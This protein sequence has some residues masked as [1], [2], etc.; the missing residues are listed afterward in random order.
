MSGAPQPQSAA[1]RPPANLLPILVATNSLGLA[2]TSIY[3]PSLPAIAHTLQVSAAAAQNTMTV[4]LVAYGGGMLLVGPL[5]DHLGRRRLLI[6]GTT[7]FALASVLAA[8]ANRIDVLLVARALQAIGACTGMALGRAI[9]RDVFSHAGTARAMAVISVALG[10]TPILA[11]LVGGYLQV[12]WGWRANF[13][14]LALAGAAITAAVLWRIPETRQPHADGDPKPPLLGG[15]SRLLRERRYLG[16]T[17]VIGGTS[18]MFYAF[19]TAAPLILITRLGVTPDAF[20]RYLVLGTCGTVVSSVWS[21]HQVHKVGVD[22]LIGIGVVTLFLAGL[23]LGLLSSFLH[24]WA[25]IAPLFIVALGMGLCLP[26]AN[27]G[28][29]GIFPQFAGAAAGL[30]GC[31]QMIFCSAATLTMTVTDNRTAL[32]LAGAWVCAALVAS[33]G[34]LLARARGPSVGDPRL[35]AAA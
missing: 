25:I 11:P 34:A 31:I 14:F 20:G 29:L 30:S 1:M 23:L 13:G 3:A 33:A 2:A 16:Y 35:P 15:V 4:Y 9:V 7:L 6:A 5:S 28:G 32:P 21:R 10:I 27:A 19:L 8:F 12:W 24:P 26:N 22:Y 17:L 18:S